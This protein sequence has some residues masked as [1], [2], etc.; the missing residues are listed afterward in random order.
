MPLPVLILSYRRATLLQSCLS[1]IPHDRDILIVSDGP[2]RP[3]HIKELNQARSV[4]H[5]YC[6]SNPRAKALY[7]T[8]NLGG[9]IGIPKSIDLIFSC[10]PAAVI[11]EEDC[12]VSPLAWEYFDNNIHLVGSSSICSLSGNNFM[13]SVL[14][15]TYK[16]PFRSLYVS[17]WG[18]A[19]T[20]DA[21]AKL[22]PNKERFLDKSYQITALKSLFGSLVTLSGG[23]DPLFPLFWYF[24]Y[25]HLFLSHK[26]HWDFDYML[27]AWLSHQF[28]LLP[29]VHLTGHIGFGDMAQNVKKASAME[30]ADIYLD[31]IDTLQITPSSYYLYAEHDSTVMRLFFGMTYIRLLVLVCKS[32]LVQSRTLLAKV[33]RVS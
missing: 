18:W 6:L 9:P 30:N 31:T 33:G 28:S 26:Y 25:L 7:R 20:A 22:R 13:A 3:E 1:Q 4:I 29:P 11:L 8:H 24:K 32:F 19:T 2:Q 15:R 27:Q 23:R 14:D 12:S 5:N 17:G 10:Y 16:A 21:W